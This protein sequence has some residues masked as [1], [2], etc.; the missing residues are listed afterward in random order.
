MY[1]YHV[2]YDMTEPDANT[3]ICFTFVSKPGTAHQ[4]S[5]GLGWVSIPR[6]LLNSLNRTIF[7]TRHYLPQ[8]NQD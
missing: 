3:F 4:V 6:F 2:S 7:G 1:N 8:E 5:V